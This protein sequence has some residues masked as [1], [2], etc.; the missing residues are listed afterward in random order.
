M[1]PCR[2]FSWLSFQKPLPRKACCCGARGRPLLT[3]TLTFRTSTPGKHARP[4]L[5]T[6]IPMAGAMCIHTHIFSSCLRGLYVCSRTTAVGFFIL[7]VSQEDMVKVRASSETVLWL[8]VSFMCLQTGSSGGEGVGSHL[9]WSS[10]G[11]GKWW[12]GLLLSG[13][14]DCSRV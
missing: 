11:T 9:P 3:E 2:H 1:C 14:G 10:P 8:Q 12:Q 5:L 6:G 7:R 13:R 4:P